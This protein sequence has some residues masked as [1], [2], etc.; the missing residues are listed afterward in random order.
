M[1]IMDYKNL[2]LGRDQFLNDNTTN[3]R[4]EISNIVSIISKHSNIKNN[5][6]DTN[7]LNLL[8]ETELMQIQHS[9]ANESQ[10]ELV[11][12]IKP[13]V[14][15]QIIKLFGNKQDINIRVSAQIKSRW[16]ND[17]L[18]EKR[19]VRFGSNGWYEDETKPNMAYPT[20]AHQDL[21]NNGNRSSHVIIF[22]FQIT[23]NYKNCSML[24][25][26]SFRNKL[27]IIENNDRNGYPNE[28]TNEGM[29]QVN[30]KDPIIKPGDI[31]LMSPLTIH[32]STH[33][34]EIPR[35]ALNVKFQ[36]QNLD[37]MKN[38]YGQNLGE[39]V[40]Y[41]NLRE[42]LNYLKGVLESSIKFNRAL[43]FEKA[44][45]SLLLEDIQGFY[46]DIKELL[47]Y[48][49]SLNNLNR[50][51]A[52]CILRKSTHFISK[53]DISCLKNPNNYIVEGSCASSILKTII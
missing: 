23:E 6:I 19:K 44:T 51:A 11:S 3:F 17:T 48:D 28:I 24:Q 34:A 16:G 49:I 12:I 38:I 42:K 4:S 35:I 30:W 7:H 50:L 43:L 47:D 39:L 13:Y 33:I 20:R 37:Y 27:C 18:I 8:S 25:V 45:V 22:Y 52:A 36:P 5:W 40:N 21:D 10:N 31:A 46:K 2:F 32:R 26:G 41:K 1:S 29:Q 53:D 9:V 15:P 14:E